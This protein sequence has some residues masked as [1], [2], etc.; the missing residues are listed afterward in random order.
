MRPEEILKSSNQSPL[1]KQDASPSSG[2]DAPEYTRSSFSVNIKRYVGCKGH[3][4]RLPGGSSCWSVELKDGLELYIYEENVTEETSVCDQCRIIGWGTHPVCSKKYHFVI[5]AETGPDSLDDPTSLA[6]ITEACRLGK[7]HASSISLPSKVISETAEHHASIYNADPTIYDSTKHRLHGVIH[8]NGYG[9]LL[10][11]NGMYG[12]SRGVTGLQIMALWDVLCD[13][14]Q[15]KDVTVED[16]SSKSGMEL[17]I[18]YFLGYGQTWYGLFGYKFGRGPY[19]ITEKRWEDA[20]TYVSSTLLSHI[21]HDFEGVE[22]HVP[23]IIQRYSLPV[24]GAALV[25]DFG[26]LLYRL[27]YLQLNPKQAAP[28]FDTKCI[29]EAQEAVS[30]GE[31]E[32][33]KRKAGPFHKKKRKGIRFSAPPQKKKDAS[34][35]MKPTTATT[36]QIGK[37]LND[38]H[39]D[40]NHA[41]CSIEDVTLNSE[42]EILMRDEIVQGTVVAMPVNR[43]RMHKLRMMDG[44]ERKFDLEI[45][46]WRLKGSCA[47]MSGSDESTLRLLEKKE[48]SKLESIKNSRNNSA[49]PAVLKYKANLSRDDFVERARQLCRALK[50]LIPKAKAIIGQSKT[51]SDME[52][53]FSNLLGGSG[54]VVTCK[55]SWWEFLPV[56]LRWIQGLLEIQEGDA[57]KCITL[58]DNTIEIDRECLH[59]MGMFPEGWNPPLSKETLK[60]DNAHFKLQNPSFAYGEAAEEL[61]P[62]H[63]RNTRSRSAALSNAV[64]TGEPCQDGVSHRY[65]AED[66]QTYVRASIDATLESLWTSALSPS[67]EDETTRISRPWHLLDPGAD[68]ADPGDV[69]LVRNQITRDLHYLFMCTLKIYLPE[70]AKIAAKNA[71]AAFQMKTTHK[72]LKARHLAKEVQ[73][74]RDTKLFMKGYH[75]YPEPSKNKQQN[76][77]ESIRVWTRIEM[78][79]ELNTKSVSATRSGRKCLSIIPPPEILI[80]DISATIKQYL[81]EVTNQFRELYHMFSKFRAVGVISPENFGNKSK[82]VQ[83]RVLPENI[84][85]RQL[86]GPSSI[87]LDLQVVGEGYILDSVWLH[88]GGPEDWVVNCPCGTRDDDGEAMVACDVCETWMHTRCVNV[89]EGTHTWSC[90]ACQRKQNAKYLS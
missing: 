27:L 39:V 31:S 36:S 61:S 51:R 3:E 20:G 11:I 77:S 9:H 19:N 10:R 24:G 15:A 48:E 33:K 59:H 40:H 63:T 86:L 84:Q 57:S 32:L 85:L 43:G 75:S 26:A 56:L 37:S 5:P 78:P 8:G 18:S 29:A 53:A 88:A 16:V 65:H 35:D 6:A 81:D 52:A 71:A 76:N 89:P 28:F 7:D 23:E 90:D 72:V 64:T 60:E 68:V 80:M 2:D 25:R 13:M 79:R 58:V 62:R 4:I 21:L 34:G 12:G 73:V 70:V 41:P 47:P 17:R 50:S 44:K 22:E 54:P 46:P 30:G 42:L 49:N 82:G 83:S 69:N 14:L 67:D 87:G 1:L 38:L 66:I 74:L 55:D 45:T